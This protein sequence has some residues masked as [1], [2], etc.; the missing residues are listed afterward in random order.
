MKK[1]FYIGIILGLLT[2]CQ[3]NKMNDFDCTGA[4]YFQ[5]DP[6]YWS[7]VADSILYSFAGKKVTEKTFNI[8][9]NLL[10]E[11]VDRDRKIRLVV[12]REKTTAEVGVHYRAL[13]DLYILPK[14]ANNIQIPVT[15]F[16]GDERLKKEFLQLTLKLEASDDLQL[17]L[18]NR[19]VIRILMADMYM[20][21]AYW[22]NI[23]W[24]WG[25]YSVKKHSLLLE[26]FEVDFPET[27]LEY[28]KDFYLWQARANMIS[29]YVEENYPVLDENNQPIEPWFSK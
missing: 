5:I 9:V 6:S 21:P 14:N 26:Q 17:G 3:E 25:N 24:Y 16:Q 22:D 1:I 7:N 27:A 10:G 13:E 28:S 23:S 8:Q 15:L 20:K 19:T 11:T 2:A 12:D 18:T 4:V 29:Q